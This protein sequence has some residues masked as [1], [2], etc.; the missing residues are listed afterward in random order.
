MIKNLKRTDRIVRPFTIHKNWTF[1]KT[2]VDEIIALECGDDLPI[3]YT[4]GNNPSEC[5]NIDEDFLRLI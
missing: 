4:M 2:N 5:L 3:C 1:N